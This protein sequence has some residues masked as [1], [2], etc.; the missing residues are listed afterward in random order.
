MMGNH[1]CMRVQKVSW[2]LRNA[3]YRVHLITSKIPYLA[4]NYASVTVYENSDQM[5]NAVELHRDA[6]LFHVHNEPSWFVACVKETLPQAKVVLDLHDSMLLRR[7]ER[8]VEKADDPAVF[9]YS[10]DERSNLQLADGHV[11]VCEPMRKLATTTYK[12]GQPHAVVPSAVPW[13]WMRFDHMK[14]IGGLCYEG[15]VDVKEDLPAQWDFFNYCN[16]VPFA[17]ACQK[18]GVP[19][20]LYTTRKNTEVRKVYAPRCYL[21]PEPLAYDVLLKVIG[22]HDWG[23]VGNLKPYTEWQHALPNKLFEYWAA[24][25]PAVCFNAKE[26][27]RFLKDTGMGIT[28]GSVEELAGRWNESRTCRANIIKRRR[29]FALER[30][31]PDLEDLYTKVLDG[32]KPAPAPTNGYAAL[33]GHIPVGQPVKLAP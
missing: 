27:S 14:Y 6:D 24:G 29:E 3:G 33:R 30:W 7:T 15:R 31:L 16:Y 20:Y 22:G 11:F 32:E 26:S 2:V 4:E 18:V 19:F 25:L 5:R 21:A 10:A 9:R 8:E 23:L 1:G 13:Q 17:E 28:V 12:L